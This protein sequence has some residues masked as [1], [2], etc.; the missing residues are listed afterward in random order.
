MNYPSVTYMKHITVRLKDGQLFREE[1]ENLVK[2]CHIH[3]SVSDRNGHC[4]GGHLKEGCA[5]FCTIELV[6]GILEEVVYHRTMD[7]ETGFEELSVKET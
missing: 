1:V 3:V 7:A 2:S 4:F 5:V 6:I